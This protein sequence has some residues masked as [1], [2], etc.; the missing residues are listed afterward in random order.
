M[1][2]GQQAQLALTLALARQPRLLVLDEPLAMLDPLAR[3]DFMDTVMTAASADGLS[4]VLS[5]HV[6][7]EL[8]RVANYLIV[9]SRGQLQLAGKVDELLA[10]HR[11]LVGPAAEGAALAGR[12]RVV[13]AAQN[14][15]E[16]RMLVAAADPDSPLPDGLAGASAEPGGDGP[17][18]SARARGVS[19]PRHRRAG[20]PGGGDGM[21]AVTMPPPGPAAAPVRPVSWLKLA[22]VGWRQHRLALGGVL[23]LLG[24]VCLWMLISGLQMRSALS[25]FG[26]NSCTPLTASSCSTQESVFISDY[27]SGAQTIVGVLQVVPVL[28]GVLLGAPM[29]A[30][31]LESGTFRLS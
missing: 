28:A 19:G 7:A 16:S 5:S 1:S 23:T 2:G 3:F 20:W 17:G 25:S 22:W 9:L 13:H 15:D 26:L 11:V 24:G 12:L 29:V 14:A 18:L 30:R 21:T 8:E 27:Y 4:V 6:L 10:G 31:E